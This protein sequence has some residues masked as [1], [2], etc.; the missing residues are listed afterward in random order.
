MKQ[1]KLGGQSASVVGLGL[2]Q[3]GSPQWGWGAD[4]GEAAAREIV[5][6]ALELGINVFDTAEMYGDGRSEEILARALESRRAEAIIATKVS[7]THLRRSRLKEAADRSLVRLEIDSIDLYQVHWPNR[8]VRQASTMSGMR[9][10]LEAEKIRQVGVSNYPLKL[11][12]SAERALGR[13]IV[14]NQVQF[15]LLDQSPLVDLVPYAQQSG[16]VIIA[17]SPLAQGA[18]GGRY[19]SGNLPQDFRNNNPMFSDSGFESIAPLLYELRM[20]G[21]AHQAT[22]A[23]IALAWLLHIPQVMVI[24]GA[25]TVEQVEANAAAA[26][27]D[28]SEA[29]WT[30]LREIAESV[31]PAASR[32]KLTRLAGWLLGA[33]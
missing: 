8:F 25:R 7:P 9:D 12:Q 18:L 22:P 26:D 20:V 30:R 11:W 6:R 2:W 27:I 4:L 17:Y 15:H 16:S 1:V 33:R 5:Q 19:N 31:T 10:L 28:L 13:P 3:F 21:D 29:E 14:A 32:R 24:P 23:Q